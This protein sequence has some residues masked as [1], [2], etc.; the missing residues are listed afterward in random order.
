MSFE[1]DSKDRAD[2]EGAI[3]SAEPIRAHAIPYPPLIASASR[4]STCGALPAIINS[5]LVTFALWH[6]RCRQSNGPVQSGCQSVLYAWRMRTYRPR[7][8]LS[9]N[10][11]R[12]HSVRIFVYLALF[13][14]FVIGS[15]SR[16]SRQHRARDSP[17]FAPMLI[18]GESHLLCSSVCAT[19]LVRI[20]T[21]IC[22]SSY[23]RD[24]PTWA[25]HCAREAL[26]INSS[27]GR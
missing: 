24:L 17:P 27:A 15:L 26:A 20:G 12:R 25:A 5:S 18:L 9:A 19:I 6:I 3:V 21:P 1:T 11:R 23:T 10:V 22:A 16:A 7:A 14:F 2:T 4:W 13:A 8:A